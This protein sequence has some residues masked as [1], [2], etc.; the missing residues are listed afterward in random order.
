MRSFALPVVL[1]AALACGGCASS[2]GSG[3]PWFA[4]AA[5]RVAAS[6]RDHA[7]RVS[8]GLAEM[9]VN[10]DV[11]TARDVAAGDPECPELTRSSRGAL[12][13]AEEAHVSGE[14]DQISDTE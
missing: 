12:S 9:A 3:D 10:A 13:V 5:G 7:V 1:G 6:A 2:L 14:V 11:C 8:H 4:P